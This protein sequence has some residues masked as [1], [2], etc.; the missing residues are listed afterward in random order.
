MEALEELLKRNPRDAHAWNTRGATLMNWGVQRV[1]NGQDPTEL[2]RAAEEDLGKAIAIHAND[3]EAHRNRGA[4]RMNAAEF[5]AGRGD[6][7]AA[8]RGYGQAAADFETSLRLN[9]TQPNLAAWLAR[10]K[11]GA[12]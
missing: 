8:R 6:A 4:L 5:A 10:C 1:R 11:E 2:Y 7:E 9:G 12:K 3:F